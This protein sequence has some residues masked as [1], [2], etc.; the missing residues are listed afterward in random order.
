M[1]SGGGAR[2]A[3]H[4]GV[5]K[6]LDDLHVPID[7][8]AGTSM[9]A[10]VGG[11]YASGLNAREIESVMTSVNWEHAFRDRPPRVDL[12]FRRKEED[13]NFLVQYPLG[14]RG[15]RLQLPKGFIDGQTLTMTLR[16]LTLP[17]ARTDDFDRLPTA[18]RA[19]A[20]DLATGEPVVMRAGDLTTAMRASLSAPGVFTPVERDGRVLVDGGISDNLPIDVARQMHVD[21]LIVVDVGAALYTREHLGSAATISNQMLAILIRRDSQRQLA[22]LGASDVVVTPEL[23]LSSF[24]FGVVRRAVAAGEAAARGMTARLAQLGASP[25]D[26]AAYLAQRAAGRRNPPEVKFVEVSPSSQHYAGAL[27]ELFDPMI[28]KPLDPSDADKRT[29]VLYGQGT[30]ELLDYRLVGNDDRYGMLLTARRNSWGPNYVR[31]GLSLQD[32]FEGNAYYNAAARF[33]LTDLSRHGAEWVWDLQVGVDPHIYSEFYLPFSL[34]SPWFVMPHAQYAAETLPIVNSDLREVAEYRV[35]STDYG[36]DFGK[37]ISNY[38][39]IR[40]GFLHENGN[41]HVRIGDPTL[42]TTVFDYDGYFVRASYDRL[43]DVRFP[44]K[45][46]LVELQWNSQKSQT[47]TLSDFNQVIFNALTAHSFGRE[48]A[49]LWGSAGLTL[50]RTDPRNVLTQFPLGG[51]FN[52]SG[53]PLKSLEGP[54]FA[55]A[56]LLLYRKIGRGGEGLFD[57]PAYVGFSLEAGNVWQERADMSWSSLRKDASIFVGFDTILGPVYIATGFDQ[58]GNEQFY[59]SLG[60][61]F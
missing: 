47:D 26:Y 57:F 40:T 12:D 14:I 35:N 16:R 59:L 56:R 3:A 11:L 5:L 23:D 8:I 4:I 7:A 53:L 54:D 2:G 20:T 27:H 37:E 42:P 34:S 30:L 17:V 41:S 31:F 25:A 29:D 58:S 9:G 6:V 55:I 19:V 33:V 52:L 39:E 21:I 45:G 44:S 10:V 60:R 28:G 24:E 22:T 49:I 15:H 13:R 46:E 36:L 43:D 38:G 1:L 48:T 61:T 50:N 32:D 51:L 18:F